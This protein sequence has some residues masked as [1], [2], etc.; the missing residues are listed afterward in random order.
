M[1]F[2]KKHILYLFKKINNVLENENTISVS[3]KCE[4]HSSVKKTGLEI[5]GS[6]KIGE[7]SSVHQSKFSGL[8]TVGNLCTITN[9][10][11]AGD[12]TIGSNS[13]I[14][15]GTLLEGEIV[16]G[17][18]TS[19]NGPNTD[20]ICKLN[21]IQI[22]NFC[23]IARNVTFQEFNHDFNR[24]TSYF[25]N[26]N[27]FRK[28]NLDDIVS[29]GSIVLGHDVWI[30]THSVILSGVKIGTGAVV[31]ANSVVVKDVPPYA[32]VGG[33]PAKI[34]KY[35]FSEK[36]INQLLTSKWWEKSEIEIAE[37]YQKFESGSE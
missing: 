26:A 27:M 29:K 17:K 21:S 24:L 37:L 36:I 5:N 3:S 1:N 10:K 20:L 33:N 11:L 14:V 34:I 30:G 31:A 9:A 28:S 7:G 16:I 13:K 32:I 25:I 18:F 4:I 15:A 8:V 19:I 23:S 6:V 22:G 12:I 2:F 35:R